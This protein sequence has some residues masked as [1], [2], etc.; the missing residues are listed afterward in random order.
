MITKKSPMRKIKQELDYDLKYPDYHDGLRAFWRWSKNKMSFDPFYVI[1][2]IGTAVFALSGTMAAARK[3]LDIFG[4]MVVG[5]AP[6]IGGGTVRD[7][8][9]DTRSNFPGCGFKLSLCGAWGFHYRL[10]SGPSP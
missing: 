7:I 5:L 8:L 1:A 3:E 6:A 9:L 2:M 10:F 4:F